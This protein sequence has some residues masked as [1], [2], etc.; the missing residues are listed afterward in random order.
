[1]SYESGIRNFKEANEARKKKIACYYNGVL[2]KEY[3]CICDVAKDG[4]DY[5]HASRVARGIRKSHLG[6]TFNFI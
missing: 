2:V 6:H 5:H 4:F 1:M 3:D